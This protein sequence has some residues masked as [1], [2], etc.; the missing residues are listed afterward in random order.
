E[1]GTV[2]L[3]AAGLGDDADL[4]AG[5]RAVL[6]R[7]AARFDPELLDVLEARLELERG[8]GFAVDVARRRVD[9]GGPFDA[10][11]LDDVLFVR[12]AAEADVLPGA[13]PGVLRP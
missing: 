10:V 7:V 9:D 1:R 12:P 8:V 3:V 11:V 6:S 4:A 13:G 5:P 2:K